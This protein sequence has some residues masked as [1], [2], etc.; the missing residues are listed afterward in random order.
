LKV[1]LNM[2]ELGVSVQAIEQITIKGVDA[3]QIAKLLDKLK[4]AFD[5][6]YAKQ[7]PPPKEG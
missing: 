2:S 5:K 3:P 6:E 1:D 4:K 7:P